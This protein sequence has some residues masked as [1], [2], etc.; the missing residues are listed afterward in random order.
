MQVCYQLLVGSIES[1]VWEELY[2]SILR[3]RIKDIDITDLPLHKLL[4]VEHL[5]EYL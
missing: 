2:H 5:Q 1:G 4:R 3:E